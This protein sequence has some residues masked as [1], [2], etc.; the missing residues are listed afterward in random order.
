MPRFAL[1]LA[2]AGSASRFGSNKLLET[3]DDG[4][5]KDASILLRSLFAFEHRS[6][7]Q[8]IVVAGGTDYADILDGRLVT[9]SAGGS[10]RAESVRNALALIDPN[11]DFVAVHDAARPLI[12]QALIDRLFTAATQ[13]GSAVPATLLTSTIKRG[14][15]NSLPTMVDRTE[16]RDQLFAVQTPQVVKRVDLIYA[17]DHCPI[18]LSQ[19]TDE[20]ML[21]ELVGLP[22]H[23]IQGEEENIKI[24]RPIDLIIAQALLNKPHSP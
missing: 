17:F 21:L 13:L 20:A 22:V 24:T 9:L 16:P 3:L 19:I 18:P 4:I 10:C 14:Q 5:K 8:Q 11:A 15:S 7:I 1:I 6:D 2:A 23:L 12:S